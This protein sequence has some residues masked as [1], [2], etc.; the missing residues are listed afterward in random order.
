MGQLE[1][2]VALVTGG[3][4]GIGLET[5]RRFTREGAQV[6]LTGR[7]R[8]VVDAAVADIGGDVTGIVG[9]VSVLASLD[10]LFATIAERSGRLDV[11]VANAGG[12]R[13]I[14]LGDISEEHYDT[15]FD[16]NVKGL[17]FTVQ[18]A[19]P[20]LSA[21]ASVVLL[22]SVAGIKGLPGMSVYAATKAAI[23]N[24]ARSWAIELAPR[25]IRVIALCPGPVATPGFAES[26]AQL[27][28]DD[29]GSTVTVPM[30]RLGE[31]REIAAAALFLA[32]SESS[33]VTGS[34]LIIDGGQAI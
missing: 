13:L 7:R 29:D 16:I 22:S 32:S 8:D 24:L 1:G 19:L 28:D 27:P 2:K 5:A 12:G 25:G 23:R 15:T 10:A 6:Y 9:D 31:A 18:K 11:L 26:V 14:P 3:S 17:V 21:G 20:L 30:G 33:Y 34:D 4:A